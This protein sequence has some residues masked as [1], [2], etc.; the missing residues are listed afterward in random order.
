MEKYKYA[1]KKLRVAKGVGKISTGEIAEGKIFE[2]ED[3]WINIP[4]NVSWMFSDGNPACLEY[5]IRTAT[6]KLKIPTFDDK[7]VYGKIGLFG[8]LF[9][10]NELEIIKEGE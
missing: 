6:Q 8:H 5:A 1:G 9:H 4:G 7:V 2:A 3:Y 10:E